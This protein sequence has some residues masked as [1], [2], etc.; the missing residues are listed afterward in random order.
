MPQTRGRLNG[1]KDIAGALKRSVRTVQ[2]WE[3]SSGLPVYRQGSDGEL[4]FAYEHELDQW[5]RSGQ[6]RAEASGSDPGRPASKPEHVVGDSG[7]FRLGPHC[8]YLDDRVFPL[9]DGITV[10][11][12]ADDAD[13]QMLV[14]SVSRYHARI[15][16]R[17]EDATI[18]DLGSRHGSWLGATRVSGPAKLVS[19]HEI[20]LGSALLI[21]RFARAE[22][23]TDAVVRRGGR[24]Q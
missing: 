15:E 7:R 12:R 2:R 17:S 18:E 19:G 23:S 1:W 13:V 20:R 14:P 16:V 8:L 22:D 10:I 9:R 5:V 3:H 11:G 21:Y 24:N 4:I 6:N